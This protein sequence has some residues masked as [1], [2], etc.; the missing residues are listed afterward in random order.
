MIQ[1]A[2]SDDNERTP[3]QLMMPIRSAIIAISVLALFAATSHAQQRTAPTGFGQGAGRPALSPYLN[4]ANNGD[5]AINYYGLV[6]PQIAIGRAISSLNAD[7]NTLQSQANDST[8]T[9]HVS[10]FMTQG[11]YFMTNGMASKAN[12][13]ANSAAGAAPAGRR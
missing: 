6:R 3:G 11:R 9:G 13:P 7:V 10:S 5:P 8:Q 12:S 2:I 4:L 1:A